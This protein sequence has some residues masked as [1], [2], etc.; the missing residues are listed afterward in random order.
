MIKYS[1]PVQL[2]CTVDVHG[3]AGLDPPIGV[4]INSGS[5]LILYKPLQ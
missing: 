4:L 5:L 1:D 3:S 2:H